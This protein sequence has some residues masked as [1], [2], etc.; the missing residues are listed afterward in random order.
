M[1]TYKLLKNLEYFFILL[2]ILCI[3][4]VGSFYLSQN[5]MTDNQA[6]VSTA[7][8]ADVNADDRVDVQDLKPYDFYA[9]QIDTRD[10]FIP[11]KQ[12]KPV[13]VKSFGGQLPSNFKVVGIIL[14]KP[15]QVIIEDQTAHQT[16]FIT[17]DA[18]VNGIGIKSVSGDAIVLNY[19][20]QSIQ[21]NIKGNQVN[22]PP[23]TDP[24]Q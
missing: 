9:K 12:A 2:T 3:G 15:V 16:Y 11:L 4:Y 13:E 20:G 24:T 10:V 18:P 19:Q 14:A 22:V 23:P 1:N 5:K 21:V 8:S 6:A 7:D 17:E